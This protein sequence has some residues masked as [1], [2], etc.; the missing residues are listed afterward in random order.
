MNVDDEMETWRKEWQSQPAVP[1]DLVRKI[2]RETI[3]MRQYRWAEKLVTLLF[4]G[5]S[6]ALAW[7]LP[8]ATTLLFAVGIW[9]FLALAWVFA[10]KH[11]KGLW[12]PQTPTMAAYLDLAIRRCRWRIADSRYDSVQGVLITI[13]VFVIDFQF[14]K[15]ADRWKFAPVGPTGFGVLCAVIAIVVAVSYERKRR[16]AQAELKSLLAIQQQFA[17]TPD[18]TE[19]Q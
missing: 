3:H 9:A 18:S 4:G 2:E 19:L 10:L 6:I 8:S 13:F 15:D 7:A 1:I 17:E 14:L 16:G 5:G 12:E 11:T